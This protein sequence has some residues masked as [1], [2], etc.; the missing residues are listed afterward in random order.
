[1]K[2]ITGILSILLVLSLSPNAWAKEY[3]FTKDCNPFILME[4]LKEAGIDLEGDD[5]VGSLNTAG[6]KIT[7]ITK[8]DIDAVKLDKVIKAHKY[9]SPT[10]LEK[11]RIE[12]ERKEKEAKKK[13]VKDLLKKALLAVDGVGVTND[14][15]EAF[16]E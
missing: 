5:Q 2:K 10:Q 9:I 14:E 13:K 8:K 11:E 15:I 7:I 4:E 16:L 3:R 1:M 6:N 12:R